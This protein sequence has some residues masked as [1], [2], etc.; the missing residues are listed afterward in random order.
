MTDLLPIHD[1]AGFCQVQT[2]YHTLVWFCLTIN[3]CVLIVNI[4]LMVCRWMDVKEEQTR[5]ALR[6]A[7]INQREGRKELMRAEQLINRE[8]DTV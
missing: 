3:V 7:L 6:A 5:Q 1:P 2:A 8:W 4:R